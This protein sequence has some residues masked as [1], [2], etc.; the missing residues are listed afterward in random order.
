MANEKTG[1]HSDLTFVTEEVA[2]AAADARWRDVET[3]AAH[4][5]KISLRPC[6]QPQRCESMYILFRGWAF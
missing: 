2:A 1:A 6:L 5:T 4:N 3:K